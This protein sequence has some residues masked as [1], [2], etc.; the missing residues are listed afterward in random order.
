MDIAKEHAVIGAGEG[1]SSANPIAPILYAPNAPLTAE[2]MAGVLRG[3]YVVAHQHGT[4]LGRTVRGRPLLSTQPYTVLEQVSYTEIDGC[5][6]NVYVPAEATHVVVVL[7]EGFGAHLETANVERRV[8]VIQGANSDT[9]SDTPQSIG[10]QTRQ[11]PVVG[12]GPWP[13]VQWYNARQQII[14]R[15]QLENCVAGNRLTA[16]VEGR[17]RSPFGTVTSELI[18]AALFWSVNG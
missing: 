12:G 2:V 10:T 13:G 5:R 8:V 7:T 18:G 15:V 9:G 14:C 3:A 17:N 16:Y 11:T 1:Y 6:W 4:C